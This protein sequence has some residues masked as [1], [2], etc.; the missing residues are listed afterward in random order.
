MRCTYYI[1]LNHLGLAHCAEHYA[2]ELLTL[3][4]EEEVTKIFEFVGNVDN[5][6]TASTDQIQDGIL[7]WQDGK[8]TMIKGLVFSCQKVP[9]FGDFRDYFDMKKSGPKTFIQF[10]FIAIFFS[11]L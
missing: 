5:F 3:N 1:L 2:G 6:L 11:I 7:S 4:N 9:N 10:I 8:E